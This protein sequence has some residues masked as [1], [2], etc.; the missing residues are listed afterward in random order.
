[1]VLNCLLPVGGSAWYP[2]EAPEDVGVCAKPQRPESAAADR[3]AGPPPQLHNLTRK[4]LRLEQRHSE[5]APLGAAGDAS[6]GPGPFQPP[7]L[8][9]T[10][11][12]GCSIAAS[13]S[14]DSP[15]ADELPEAPTELP[16]RHS[17]EASTFG[18]LPP[19]PEASAF[20]SLPPLPV[21]PPQHSPRPAAVAVTPLR[22]F[23]E[24][25]TPGYS[26][27]GMWSS[28]SRNALARST[29]GLDCSLLHPNSSASKGS[30]A[31]PS[32]GPCL[33]NQIPN[34]PTAAAK[35][36]DRRGILQ[37]LRL[38][39]L[40]KFRSVHDALSRFGATHHS[41][42]GLSS[43]DFCLALS[44]LGVEESSASKVFTA[45]VA[46]P[47]GKVAISDLRH[48]LVE[49]SP[50]AL[51][52]ELRCRLFS[53]GI[54]PRCTQQAI[55]KAVDLVEQ[56]P[57]KSTSAEWR[58]RR[59]TQQ[60][61]RMRVKRRRESCGARHVATSIGAASGFEMFDGGAASEPESSSSANAQL[62]RDDWQR[63]CSCLDLTAFETDAL[64]T[65]L[66][67]D[68]V[69]QVDLRGMLVVLRATVAPDVSLERFVTRL[70]ARYG[71]LRC[72][73]EAACAERS[74]RI[75]RWTE[76][77]ELAESLDVNDRNARNLWDVLSVSRPEDSCPSTPG[78][79][80]TT[81]A[82]SATATPAGSV[83]PTPT[84]ANRCRGITEDR[85][86]QQLLVWAPGTAIDALRDQLCEKFGSLAQGR[87]TLQRTA[88]QLQS[89]FERGD[90]S[91]LSF[92]GPGRPGQAT[93]TV[94]ALEA[95]LQANG[96][97]FTNADRCISAAAVAQ[98]GCVT[99]DS[100]ME[101]LRA[102]Q[103][104]PS[105]T[106]GSAEAVLRDDTFPLWKRLHDVQAD[107]AS[108]SRTWE[109]RDLGQKMDFAQADP[110]AAPLSS[111][112][113]GRSLPRTLPQRSDISGSHA[114]AT[115]AASS[116][117]QRRA[118]RV[119]PFTPLYQAVASAVRSVSRRSTRSGRDTQSTAD[120]TTAWDGD[121]SSELSHTWS[122]A[123]SMR[124]LSRSRDRG[125][126]NAA[127]SLQHQQEAGTKLGDVDSKSRC[128]NRLRQPRIN[129]N[130]RLVLQPRQ[131]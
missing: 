79:S 4:A 43:R 81:P 2:P 89:A 77:Q 48:A 63:F 10:L 20:G 3:S 52:W 64:F 7:T 58:A 22:P 107:L 74:D 25:S 53:V 100:F 124:Q 45:L 23:G 56:H 41:E 28:C 66:G 50:D 5:Q 54:Q 94:A 12:H 99:L 110:Q 120:A 47:S 75:M 125:K 51:L 38:Q 96:L 72:A 127:R 88:V 61:K 98:D 1:M 32:S 13:G 129:A 111:S 67:G 85:F 95:L 24:L 130:P 14:A 113:R 91:C 114:A 17:T 44:R 126:E 115:A 70:L 116:A 39:L 34:S 118:A 27:P 26:T 82:G 122:K 33:P 78:K 86:E 16:G 101:V 65:V 123:S 109:L 76:F 18:S 60:I 59:T 69:G 73:F 8:S 108:G 9:D 19:Q 21:T 92:D 42:R 68:D 117:A 128:A 104:R 49:D 87:R 11:P 102:T 83:A 31:T 121:H 62:D 131:T 90:G 93:L 119:N 40:E 112:M 6:A 57:D 29:P 106:H 37:N 97:D 36:R 80:M 35:R 84:H 55:R 46:A 105:K 103:R 71:S 15:M 30:G